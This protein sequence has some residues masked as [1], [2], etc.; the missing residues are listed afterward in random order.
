MLVISELTAALLLGP[1]LAADTLPAVPGSGTDAVV[2]AT[3]GAR[4]GC[5][6]GGSV[7]VVDLSGV[8]HRVVAHGWCAWGSERVAHRRACTTS[9]IGHCIAATGVA[10]GDAGSCR[11]R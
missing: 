9:V 2:L 3:A 10:G 6:A 7:L 1:E 8:D 4:A 11:A 5:A